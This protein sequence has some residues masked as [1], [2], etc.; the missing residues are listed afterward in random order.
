MDLTPFSAIN[1]CGYAGLAV[2]QARDLNIA[3][4]PAQVAERLAG[5]LIKQLE[6]S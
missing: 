4:P 1:P 5:L 3:L 6:S 2:T